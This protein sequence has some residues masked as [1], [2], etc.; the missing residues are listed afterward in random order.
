MHSPY[1]S[2]RHRG[3]SAQN[4]RRRNGPL[5][6]LLSARARQAKSIRAQQ[7]AENRQYF[8]TPGRTLAIEAFGPELLARHAVGKAQTQMGRRAR[9]HKPQYPARKN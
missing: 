2:R 5:L 7:P 1:P 3:D 6:L 4:L 9:S 8:M